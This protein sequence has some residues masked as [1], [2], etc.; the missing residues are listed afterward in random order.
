MNA[1]EKRHLDRVSALGCIIC[2]DHPAAIHHPRM[3]CGMSQRA[4]HWLAIP[5][6]AYHHQHGGYSE[7]I[8]NGQFEFEKKYGTEADL[9]AKTIERLTK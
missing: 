4:P 3:V 2:G 9:L 7:A 6:C 5:L 8:H 1:A